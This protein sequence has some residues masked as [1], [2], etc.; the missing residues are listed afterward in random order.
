MTVRHEDR[1]RLKPK[2]IAA[3]NKAM[4]RAEAITGTSLGSWDI[5]FREETSTTKATAH[6]RTES[7]REIQAW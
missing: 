7:S 1:P 3:L 4:T 2:Q 5:V 6:A